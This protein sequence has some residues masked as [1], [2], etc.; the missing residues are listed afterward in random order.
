MHLSKR[1]VKTSAIISLAVFFIQPNYAFADESNKT[2]TLE[3]AIQ[4]QELTLQSI[5]DVRLD[6]KRV[7]SAASSI[8][9]EVTREPIN[10]TTA[11]NV[12]GGSIIINPITIRESSVLEPR[13][14]WID[15]CVMKMGPVI[16]LLRKDVESIGKDDASLALSEKTQTQLDKLTKDWVST[17]KKMHSHY[18]QMLPLLKSKPYNNIAL[19]SKSRAIFLDAKALEK[20]RRKAH[21]LMKKEIQARKKEQR[22]SK[23]TK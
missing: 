18:S 16:E 4:K 22:K 21:K 5:R 14:E 11:P 13:S 6:L 19:A 17:V 23:R 7:R 10:Y 15:N 2:V 3:A 8:F 9:D 12:I 20:T 1:L